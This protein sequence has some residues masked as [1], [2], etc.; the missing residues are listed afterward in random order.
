MTILFQLVLFDARSVSRFMGKG[1]PLNILSGR[2]FRLSQ[3]EAIGTT[4]AVGGMLAT[5]IT[6]FIY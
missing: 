2:N 3:A 4:H 6:T 1:T 5:A